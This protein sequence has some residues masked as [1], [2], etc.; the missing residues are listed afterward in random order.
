MTIRDTIFG[1][2]AALT[3]A[4]FLASGCGGN[5]DPKPN[6][7]TT[8]AGKDKSTKDAGKTGETKTELANTDWGK[9]EGEVVFDGEPPAVENVDFGDSKDKEYCEK[10]DATKQTWKINAA[11]K[12]L[13]NVVVW[14]KAPPDK[15]F[16]VNP[17]LHKP[18]E[19][20]ELGQ[21]HCAFIP[22]VF[23]LYPG[24]FDGKKHVPSGQKFVIKNDATINHNSN[25]RFNQRYNKG[26]N[27]N[28]KPGESKEVPVKAGDGKP[29]A[30]D[31][32]T[33]S[34]TIHGWMSAYGR[35]FDHPFAAVTD[36]EGKFVIENAPADVELE[37]MY[38]HESMSKPE[39]AGKV[40]ITKEG[41][42]APEIKIKK[43]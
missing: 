22:H 25:Y 15:F 10:G 37:L 6:L 40:K 27:P 3:L 41:I 9:I 31:L 13:A 8:D 26:D 20:V 35:V 39:S 32:I 36:Q 24:Y 19:V 17:D 21:P 11:N 43:S 38:W 29:G 16:K 12:G 18:K 34:C 1:L 7:T 30:E 23:V 42:K 2:T 28:L 4:A 5:T 14:L 33:V